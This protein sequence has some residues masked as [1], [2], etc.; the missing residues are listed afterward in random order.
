VNQCSKCDR[1]VSVVV[2]L[3]LPIGHMSLCFYCAAT[4]A[5]M[6]YYAVRQV[7]LLERCAPERVM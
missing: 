4:L 3:T 2:D 5:E 7:D 6:L 1:V